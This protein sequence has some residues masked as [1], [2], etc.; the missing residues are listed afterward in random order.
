MFNDITRFE[1]T[2]EGGLTGN[3]STLAAPNLY[4]FPFQQNSVGNFP[5]QPCSGTLNLAT[6]EVD[7]GHGLDVLERA[8]E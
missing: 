5:G 2:F 4:R 3:D 7:P 1:V 6:G 8:S